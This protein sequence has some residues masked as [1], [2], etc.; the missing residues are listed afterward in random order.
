MAIPS[1]SLSTALIFLRPR[2][3]KLASLQDAQAKEMAVLRARSAQAVQRWY[4]LSVLGQG[5]CWAEWEGRME[6]GEKRV[7]RVEG[8]RR[9][10]VED[11]KRYMS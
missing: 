9:R 11:R 2:L 6:E 3:A 10:E 7:R 4:E 8:E 1:S 5:E